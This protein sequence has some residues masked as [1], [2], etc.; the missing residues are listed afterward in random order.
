[1]FKE[2]I[3]PYNSFNNFL[4]KL[5]KQRTYKISIDAGFSCPN[6]DGTKGVGG[7]IFCDEKGSSSRT[8]HECSSLK[9]QIINN[10]KV[11]KSRYR[12]EKFIVYFQSFTNTYAST[13]KLKKLYDEAIDAHEDIVGISVSTRPDCIDE[14]KI[15]LLASYKEKL[16]FVCV[17]YG[18]QTANDST[19]K[20]LNRNETHEDFLKALELTKKYD[21]HHCAHI[22]LGLPEESLEDNLKTAD[23]LAQLKVEG[24][25]IHSLVAMENTALC[26]MYERG[27]WTP[28]TLEEYVE[29]SCSFIERLHPTS[30][31]H[32]VSASGHPLHII[33]PLWMKEK[34][35]QFSKALIE[36]FQKRKTRQGSF[37]KFAD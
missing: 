6:R 5:F 10:I 21:L 17:E 13:E 32:R 11:R 34:N 12:A 25:K 26:Q 33:A 16:P 29:R 36:E 8:N 7:C 22:I 37:C 15:K 24:V 31:L 30:I 28:L 9:T 14:E 1:M 4:K 2:E 23:T 18:M 19:L 35:L 27:L 20:L 3:L